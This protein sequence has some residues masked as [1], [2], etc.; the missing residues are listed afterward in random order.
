[1][2]RMIS[3]Q[4]AIAEAIASEMERDPTVVI[5]G[6]DIAGGMGA[7]GEDDAWG[8]VL[9]VTKGL[10]RALPRPRDRHA[11]LR[12]GLRRR[13][14]RR[15]GLRT[16]ADRRAD[17]RRLPRRLPGP[18]LQP[19][20]QVPLHVRRQ[21]GDAD[22][23]PHD[24]R[25]GHPRGLPA[26]AGAVPDLHPHPGAEG[27]R[28]V[29]PL[30]RQGPAHPGDPRQR[31]G[32]LPRAQGALHARGR[33]AGGELHDPVR[34]GQRRARRR[35][36]DRGRARAHGRVRR[37]GGRLAGRCVLRDHRPAHHLAARRGHDPRERREHRPARRGGRGR[38]ALRHG[39][40]H[41]RAW[42]ASRRSATSR[43]RR[44]WSRR[45]TRR[46]RSRRCWR[47]P[48]CRRRRRSPPPSA[49]RPGAAQHA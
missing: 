42:S 28:A 27:R 9:G 19:G 1:M 23:H 20:G 34:R 30:R 8:G 32:D 47:T 17:V 18:D 13:R 25:R 48:T 40:G 15:R 39:R 4:Q 21:G 43:R 46:C 2:A 12:V 49:R 29:E 38:P 14:G 3:Y 10:L 35:R 26:L 16:A 41:R 36:R 6:E 44:R 45:R 22:G 7:P 24:V 37:G 5:M 33:R 11:D 31:P